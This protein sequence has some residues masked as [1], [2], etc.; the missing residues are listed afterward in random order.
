M[1]AIMGMN[2]RGCTTKIVLILSRLFCNRHLHE[3]IIR[4]IFVY[5]F[6]MVLLYSICVGARGDH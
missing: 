4:I 3:I 5:I 1:M 2:L 6:F